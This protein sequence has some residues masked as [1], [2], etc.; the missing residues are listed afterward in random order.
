MNIIANKLYENQ[1]VSSYD[2]CN[3]RL[4]GKHSKTQQCKFFF[5]V[6][7]DQMELMKNAQKCQFTE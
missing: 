7:G 4:A 5:Y 1:Y 3:S 2:Y 6:Q